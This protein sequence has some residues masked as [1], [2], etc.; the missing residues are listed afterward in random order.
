ML[1]AKVSPCIFSKLLV[2]TV[3][4]LLNGTVLYFAFFEACLWLEHDCLEQSSSHNLLIA[5]QDVSDSS[6]VPCRTCILGQ[7]H[8][9][10]PGKCG[11]HFDLF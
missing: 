3:L 6:A 8:F 1:V 2:M 11:G 5:Y 7:A 4:E 9:H 10:I